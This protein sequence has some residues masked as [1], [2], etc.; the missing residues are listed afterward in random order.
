MPSRFRLASTAWAI[1]PA[2]FVGSGWLS[3]QELGLMLTG[4][5]F[6]LVGGA[7]AA[8]VSLKRG[9]SSDGVMR[10]GAG[11][12]LVSGLAL[13]G[14]SLAAPGV[15]AP[16]PRSSCPGSRTACSRASLG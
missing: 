2:A 5:A 12:V 16:W 6:S 10:I 8:Q 7:T 11:I 14:L 13:A 1:A 15:L 9:L 4:V 3:Q